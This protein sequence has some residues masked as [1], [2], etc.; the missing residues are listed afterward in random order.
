M[1][2]MV[3]LLDDEPAVTDSLMR[4]LRMHKVQ[5]ETVAKHSVAEAISL[6]EADAVDLVVSDIKM[7][8]RDGFDF[9]HY[10]A[11]S[12]A[13]ERIPV[14][15]LTGHGDSYVKRKALEC[16]ATDLLNKPIDPVDLIVRVENLLKMKSYSDRLRNHER[17][18]SEQVRQRTA[19]LEISRF[20]LANRLAKVAEMRDENTGNHV[21]RVGCYSEIIARNYGLDASIC[22]ALFLA[23]PMHDIGKIAV[24]DAIL[25]KEGPLSDQEW[26]VMRTHCQLGAKILL[27]EHALT[28]SICSIRGLSVNVDITNDAV[29]TMAASVAL[30]H[31]E[32]WDGS[33]YP[34]GLS[35]HSIPIEARIVSVADVFDAMTTDRPYRKALSVGD[36]LDYMRKLSSTQFDP[37]ILDTFLECLPAIHEIRGEFSDIQSHSK[38]A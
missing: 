15:M 28:P 14:V 12:K 2:P 29:L 5:W 18:L 19:E 7:P 21:I 32:K 20:A 36:T 11:E 27:E 10:M 26:E 4:Y 1:I 22:E 13:V 24:P 25:H 6:I 37:C 16:G 17:E 34:D 3:L 30:R 23:A 35:E 8:N 38:A 31:H 33:G 9:L